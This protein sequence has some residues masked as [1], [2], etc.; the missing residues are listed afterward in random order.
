MAKIIE[1]TLPPEYED[2]N[3]Y[4]IYSHLE[5]LAKYVVKLKD[6]IEDLQAEVKLRDGQLQK[7][8]GY[9]LKLKS[10]IGLQNIK[11]NDMEVKSVIEDIE[12]QIVDDKK[13]PNFLP[14]QMEFIEV[15]GTLPI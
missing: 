14:P 6:Q 13:T 2:K 15:K 1:V 3:K 12:V 4:E 8:R 5:T 10:W 11:I 9:I 7:Q